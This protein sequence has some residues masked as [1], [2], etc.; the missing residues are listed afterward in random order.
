MNG[1]DSRNFEICIVGCPFCV[2]RRLLDFCPKSL[3]LSYV[4]EE[5][6]M[7]VQGLRRVFL[8]LMAMFC[9]LNAKDPVTEATGASCLL[10]AHPHLKML[11]LDFSICCFGLPLTKPWVLWL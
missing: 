4:S 3:R 7:D 2:C 6:V 8:T 1:D 10:S 9:S 5:V 11:V